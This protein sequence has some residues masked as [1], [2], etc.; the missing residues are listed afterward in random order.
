MQYLCFSEADETTCIE[1]QETRS[2]IKRPYVYGA[3]AS[4]FRWFEYP[5]IGLSGLLDSSLECPQRRVQEGPGWAFR[6]HPQPCSFS[7]RK[8]LR[9][10]GE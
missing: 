6:Y 9:V 5:V 1:P 2:G 4:F 7:A 8:R 10:C 3:R